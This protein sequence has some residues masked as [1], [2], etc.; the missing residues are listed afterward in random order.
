MPEL[1]TNTTFDTLRGQFMRL[2]AGRP[3]A[4]IHAA[5]DVHP[6]TMMRFIAGQDVSLLVVRKIQ[7]WCDAEERLKEPDYETS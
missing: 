7:R 6:N 2:R 5:L 4:T 1:L 3:L